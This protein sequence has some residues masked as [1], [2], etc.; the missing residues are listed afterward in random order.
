MREN[1]G[2]KINQSDVAAE[3]NMSRG[4]F[5]QCFARFA[6]ETFGERLRG[7]RIELAKSLLVDT[8][9]SICE[10]SSRSGFEDDRY[11]S[12]LFRERVGKL[13]SEFRASGM[14]EA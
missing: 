8:T 14:V 11:F 13:P 5:S 6:G 9:L 1:A 7:M 12:K 2:S 10:I 4:Y 3:V